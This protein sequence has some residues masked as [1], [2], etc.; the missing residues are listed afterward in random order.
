MF[1]VYTSGCEGRNPLAESFLD[2]CDEG[3]EYVTTVGGPPSSIPCRVTHFGAPFTVACA[4]ALAALPAVAPRRAATRRP[5]EG[6]DEPRFAWMLWETCAAQ[7]LKQGRSNAEVRVARRR[8]ARRCSD[9]ACVRQRNEPTTSST[10]STHRDA[11]FVATQVG[12]KRGDD[13]AHEFGVYWHDKALRLF[14]RRR[15][16]PRG[17]CAADCDAAEAEAQI[18]RCERDACAKRLVV[19]YKRK[20]SVNAFWSTR[21]RGCGVGVAAL[22]PWMET[23]ARVL[24]V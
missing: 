8:R 2:E 7:C 3:G 1:C 19:S 23:H 12:A 5:P 13:D 10:I 16:E 17:D 14:A 4:L 24:G 20:R 22:P 11:R 9:R 18:A 15:D 21:R 6:C